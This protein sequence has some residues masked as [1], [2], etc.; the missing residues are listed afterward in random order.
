MALTFTE[1]VFEAVKKISKGEVRTYGQIAKAIG[2]PGSAR[3]VGNALNKN[4]NPAIPCHR[5]IR[6]DGTTG[7]YNRGAKQKRTLL[8][9]EGALL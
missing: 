3:A 8:K 6:A 9:E 5:V 4:Y 7:G 2:K 1:K